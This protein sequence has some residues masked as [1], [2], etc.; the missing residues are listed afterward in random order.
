VPLNVATKTSL[1]TLGVVAL[2]MAVFGAWLVQGVTSRAQE[3]W[4]AEAR[5]LARTLAASFAVPLARGEHELVQRQIDQMAEMPG[6]FPDVVRVSVIDGAGRIVA[7]SDPTM[8][9][10]P[11][12]RPVPAGEELTE[13]LSVEPA[14]IVVRLPV[15]AAV[16]FGS[17][18]VAL[19]VEG[20]LLAARRART[21]VVAALL[22]TLV[23][24][25]VVL[26]W[27]LGRLV[28]RPLRRVARAVSAFS[29][30]QA[31]LGVSL[32]GPPE[33]ASLVEVFDAMAARLAANTVH[34][35]RMVDERT[36]ALTGANEQLAEA[37][38]QLRELSIT[39]PLTGLA[40]RRA[41]GD[42]LALEVERAR[43]TGQPLALVLLDLDHF[44]RLNDTLGHLEGDAALVMAARA[45][46]EGRRVGD[47]VA[48]FG[49]EEFALL[50]PGVALA[51]AVVVAERVRRGVEEA[52]L[53]AGCTASLGVACLPEHASDG[54]GLISAA[55]GALYEA[56][57]A[58]RN[59]VRGARAAVAPAAAGGLA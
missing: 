33:I 56:K 36:R 38:R 34:L 8:F 31:S 17:L 51:D 41:F 53:P 15:A 26:N 4:R 49:G 27:S 16:R 20:P 44:K 13:D 39:D 28:V 22:A 3:E 11:F 12:G 55:D 21:Q 48:R 57:A 29:P 23:V 46:A 32:R 47:L 50:L 52:R 5:L 18:E 25:V 40:N 14:Q 6:L 30:G 10:E 2:A 59:C 45:L 42:R 58:G 54:R 37:N 24:L 9:G 19:A 35:E 1:V 43:R 7:H